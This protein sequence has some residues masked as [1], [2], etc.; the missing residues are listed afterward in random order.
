MKLKITAA[1]ALALC[2]GM[3]CA[4]TAPLADNSV[5]VYGNLDIGVSSSSTS[6]SGYSN[7]GPGTTADRGAV[8]KM[9]DGG[10]GGSNWGIRGSRNVA[11]GMK[12]GFQLQGN[13]SLDTGALNAISGA[14]PS[15]AGAPSSALFNQIA[16][17]HVGGEWGEVSLGRQITPLYYAMA[18]T[19]GREGRFSGSILSTIVGMNSSAGWGGATT[20]APLGAIYDDNSIVYTTPTMKGF[21]GNLQYTVGEVAGNIQ[22]AS[23]SAATLLYAQDGLKLSAAYYMARDAYRSAAVADGTL[24]NRF[25]HLG[26]KYDYQAWTFSGSLSNG[27][28]PSGVAGGGNGASA[29]AGDANYNVTHVG[30]GYK[31]SPKY[32]ITSGYY[33]LQD[34]NVSDNKSTMVAAGLDIYL[35]RQTTI[36]LQAGQVANEGNTNMGIIFGAPVAAGVTTVAYMT[37]VRY[38][39]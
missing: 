26:A 8:I 35:D 23:R 2:S 15:A 30:L 18:S 7:G 27:Q 16:R 9:Q 36:Y 32:R 37:G 17:V 13:L 5:A 29:S 20:N 19:D 6:A 25:W 38:S 21:T 34:M 11:G 28:N 31:I 33:K 3:V 22:A 14:Y 1:A 39:F 24:N 12:A 10:I 4:Q